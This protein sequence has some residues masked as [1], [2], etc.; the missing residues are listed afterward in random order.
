MDGEAEDLLV[1]HFETSC[2]IGLNEKYKSK[3]N[4]YAVGGHVWVDGLY[5]ERF[6][7]L[8]VYEDCTWTL[9]KDSPHFPL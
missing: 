2:R 1:W 3:S 5:E 4:L 7:I 8:L 9:N 6:L